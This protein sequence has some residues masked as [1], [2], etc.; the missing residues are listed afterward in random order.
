MQHG[1]WVE[2]EYHEMRIAQARAR[3]RWLANHHGRNVA[4]KLV[5]AAGTTVVAIYERGGTCTVLTPGG[6]DD[7]IAD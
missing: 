6:K 3:A 2:G 4:I 1:Y 7:L 5:S